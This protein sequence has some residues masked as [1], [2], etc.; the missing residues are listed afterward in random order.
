MLSKKLL[1]VFISLFSTAISNGQPI[2]LSESNRI[3]LIDISIAPG[4]N[5]RG[6]RLLQFNF[7]KFK[8]LKQEIDTKQMILYTISGKEIKLSDP[9][10]DT[11]FQSNE[12]SRSWFASFKL[13]KEQIEIIKSENLSE[14]VYYMSENRK[15]RKIPVSKAEELKNI[16]SKHF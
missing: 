11:S 6:D 9:V 7:I 2:R 12:D 4:I 10:R 5:K 13:T 14:F 15:S 3:K 1:V 16:V 8:K